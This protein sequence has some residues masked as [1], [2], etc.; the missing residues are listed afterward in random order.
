MEF[1]TF[2]ISQ[3]INLKTLKLM[4]TTMLLI[5]I[6]HMKFVLNVNK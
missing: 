4:I 6:I 3:I 5:E 1:S 2:E